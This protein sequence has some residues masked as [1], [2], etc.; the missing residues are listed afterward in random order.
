MFRGNIFDEIN[1][2]EREIGL[3]CGPGSQC[4]AIVPKQDVEEVA[5]LPVAN[6]YETE[7]AVIA[8]FELPGAKKEDIELN[9]TE[10]RIEVKVER[11][12]EKKAEEK[13]GCSYE[14]R[15]RSFYGAL[16]LP[17]DVAAEQA[18]AAYKDGILRVEIP[19]AKKQDSKKRIE[20]R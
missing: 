16:P 7:S 10:G 2:I 6:I 4:V 8:A 17:S 19:K 15:S 11:K 20:V 14:M 5:R 1:R 9:I 3:M 12:L 18:N 13:D